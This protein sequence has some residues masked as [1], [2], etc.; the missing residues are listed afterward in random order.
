MIESGEIS[1]PARGWC[2][3]ATRLSRLGY[4]EMRIKEN[5]FKPRCAETLWPGS[6]H[7]SV[8]TLVLLEPTKC[9]NVE[10][11]VNLHKRTRSSKRK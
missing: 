8:W 7:R 5:I 9:A 6:M 4:D 2:T 1:G 3:V 11:Q 10:Y